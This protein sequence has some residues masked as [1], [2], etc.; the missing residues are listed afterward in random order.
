MR[1]NLSLLFALLLCATLAVA[2]PAA[3]AASSPVDDPPFLQYLPLVA[4]P[5]P[6]PP[7]DWDPRLSQRFAKIIEA[8][9]QPGQGYWRLVKGVWYGPGEP[10]FD[11]QTHIY[12]DTL[13][14]AGERQP[15]VP[16][17]FMNLDMSTVFTTVVTEA[18]PGE[19]YAGNFPMGRNVAPAYVAIPN[20][21]NPADAAW[22]MGLGSLEQ[23]DYWIHTSYGFV[24]QWT[25]AP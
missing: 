5:P 13:N 14:P 6:L 12:V 24:W 17:D 23:P 2:I 20:D 19:L 7:V 21:G 25:I 4:G 16:I 8:D 18:K 3:P 11:G 10:P 1:R 22:G 9:V 15:G